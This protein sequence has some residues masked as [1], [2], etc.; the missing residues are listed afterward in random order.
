M[1]STR[2]TLKNPMIAALLAYLIPG[3]GQLVSG[4]KIQSHHLF[5]VHLEPVYLGND[6]R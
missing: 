6:S 3:A 5:R 1:R 4:S 2:V